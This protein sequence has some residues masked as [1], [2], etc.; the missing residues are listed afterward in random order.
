MSIAV[1]CENSKNFLK[2]TENFNLEI[3]P[4][5]CLMKFK[6]KILKSIADCLTQLGEIFK[7][8]KTHTT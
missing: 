4:Q 8:K 1:Y 2:K 7:A 5:S 6:M 3:C